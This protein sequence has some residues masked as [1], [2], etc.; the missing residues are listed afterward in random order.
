MTEVAAAAAAATPPSPLS[1]GGKASA[2]EATMCVICLEPPEV[3]G[4]IACTHRFCF[5]CILRWGT[6]ATN[7]CP[8]CKKRFESVERLGA[9]AAATPAGAAAAGTAGACSDAAATAASKTRRAA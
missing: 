3:E 8:L 5:D 2:L 1:P 9:A 4:R 6:E 7:T